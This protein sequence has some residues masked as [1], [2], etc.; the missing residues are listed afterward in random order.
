MNGPESG[1]GDLKSGQESIK[2]SFGRGPR[3]GGQA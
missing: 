3:S 2:A 1:G